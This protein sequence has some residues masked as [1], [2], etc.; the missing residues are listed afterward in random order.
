[1]SVTT[2]TNAPSAWI[3]CLECYN[4]GRLVGDW[5]P[6]AEAGAVSTSQLHGRTIRP[7]TH[8]E[9]WCL[10]VEGLPE[11]REMDPMEAQRWGEI[12]EEVGD[13]QWPA[14]C[15]WVRS[16]AYAAEGDTD[17][18][19]LSDFVERYCGEW[20]S[21]RDFAFQFAEDVDLFSGLDDDATL[22]RYFHWDSW[23][24]DL[25]TDYTTERAPEH[26]VYVFRNF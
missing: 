21:F 8:E 13:S 20:P 16:G 19:V 26:G 5:Y 14:L 2:E 7:G 1:M 3:G 9:L 12:Y 15:A 10:D 11:S 25:E 4:N 23:I 24:A 17:Y 22:V 6:A 18:P